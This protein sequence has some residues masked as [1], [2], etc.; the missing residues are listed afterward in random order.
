MPLETT[1]NQ[2]LAA[3]FYDAACPFCVNMVERFHRSL[4]RRRF[5]FTPLQTPGACGMLGVDDDHL[6]D[7]MRLRLRDGQVF[8]GADAVAEIARRIWWGWPLWAL[9]RLPGAMPRFSVPID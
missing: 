8:A 7:E 5:E 1:G 3:I 9:S 6:L 4:V 2:P